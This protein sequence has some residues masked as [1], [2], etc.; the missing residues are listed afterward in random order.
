M[1]LDSDEESEEEYE[2]SLKS[3]QSRN[4]FSKYELRSRVWEL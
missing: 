2:S 3:T 4:Q 1:Q